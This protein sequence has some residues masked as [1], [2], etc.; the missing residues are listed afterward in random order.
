MPFVY[1]LRCKDGS[2]YTGAAKDVAA[3]LSRHQ[4]GH[5]ARYTRSRLPVV[6][7]FSRRCATWGAALR[8]ELRIKRLC[9]AAKEA[10]VHQARAR[11][12]SRKQRRVPA[13]KPRRKASSAPRAA[14]Q[15]SAQ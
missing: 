4:A 6:L 7:V 13:P 2:F 11:Q 9:R 12:R 1:I 10:L 3:R 8:E 14:P 15:S 5:G